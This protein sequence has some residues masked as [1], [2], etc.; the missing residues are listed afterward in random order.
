[1]TSFTPRLGDGNPRDV[2][3]R[4]SE[5][6]SI[7]DFIPV[8]NQ[9]D[10]LD[11]S[12]TDDVSTYVQDAIDAVNA[13]GGGGLQFPAG[14]FNLGDVQLKSGVS[15]IGSGRVYGG[16]AGVTYGTQFLAIDS[17]TWM[18]DTPTDGATNAG[19]FGINLFGDDT[20]GGLRFRDNENPLPCLWNEVA[21]CFFTGF[22]E[23]AILGHCT[24]SK[25]TNL[26]IEN[27]L[28]NRERGALSGAIEITYTDNYLLNIE[29]TVSADEIV[30]ADLY[31]C[32]ILL[33]NRNNFAV[34]CI[35]EISE[36]GLH[37][38]AA[39]NQ[40]VNCRCD[41]NL[42][43]GFSGIGMFTGCKA[44]NNSQAESN[45]YD[46]FYIPNDDG[47]YYG[48]MWTGCFASSDVANVH[49]YGINFA[50]AGGGLAYQRGLVRAFRSYGHATGAVR[51]GYWPADADGGRAVFHSTTFSTTPDVAGFRY[52]VPSN[53]SGVTITNFANGLMG[54]ELVILGNTNVTVAHDGYAII[55]TTG[56]NVTMAANRIYRFVKLPAG[57]S[58]EAWV[59][60]D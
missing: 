42:G 46:G 3:D 40:I 20:C 22:G 52:F 48:G 59:Q 1:M 15:L 17:P 37:S 50:G 7:M 39:D 55:T 2:G 14:R 9:A 24:G 23:Q 38:T 60:M 31:L 58:G 25:F 4:L 36:R 44:L 32:A 26:L 5:I 16:I 27:A 43:H 6:Y 21:D 45:A 41:L 57:T 29:A 19:L 47:G 53:S 18:I 30:S 54:Q 12:S 51:Q 34:D 8:A 33:A 28:L 49:R 35:G 10:I 13:A 11:Y 56:S